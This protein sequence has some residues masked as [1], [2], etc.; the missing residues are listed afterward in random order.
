[1]LDAVQ[2]RARA[3]QLPQQYRP[4]DDLGHVPGLLA[5]QA[6]ERQGIAPQQQFCVDHTFRDQNPG[7]PAEAPQVQ[8]PDAEPGGRPD[9]GN[10]RRVSQRLAELRRPVVGGCEHQHAGRVA[11]GRRLR[12]RPR[13]AHERLRGRELCFYADG[14]LLLNE[15]QLRHV[16][17]A[18]TLRQMT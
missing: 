9:R 2:A 12:Y 4:D 16:T 8:R 14:F 15:L 18:R 13:A 5:E 3:D 1:L 17:G 7:P 6:S 10:G 11:D